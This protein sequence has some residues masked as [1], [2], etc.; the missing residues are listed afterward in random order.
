MES[1]IRALLQ[2]MF[3][4]PYVVSYGNKLFLNGLLMILFLLA[5]FAVNTVR[6]QTNQSRSLVLVIGAPGEPEYAEQ[7]SSWADSWEEAAA[8]GGMQTFIIGTNKDKPDEDLRR[9]L[10]VL[11]NE[12]AKPAGELWLVF[13]GHGT[14]DGRTAKFNLRGPDISAAD[15]AAAL[16]PC[17]R[18]LAVIQCAS[19]SGPFLNALSA[20]GRVIVTATRSGYEVNATRFGGYLARAIADPAA[21]LDKDGQTSLLEAFLAA[22][23]QV[24]QFYKEQGRLMTEHALLDDN[25]DGLG[26]PA[27]WFRGVRAVKSAADGKSV[28]GVRAHQM[29]VVPGDIERQLPPEV[30]AR[31]DE[32]EQ[33]LSALRSKK[34]IMN[35]DEY[36]RQLEGIL[37]ETA[38][39]YKS[40]RP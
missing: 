29:F 1:L 7:F 39:L 33:K 30:R 15:L 10:E 32:L 25:G 27:E 11:T 21:D 37:L 40:N 23:R 6:G 31:R 28:D 14:F 26:T 12:V 18:P 19:A 5:F 38:R 17:Q 13:I 35:E 9:L 20:P 3:E 36:Y 22:S 4:T 8:K 2:R 24:A 16:K 34:T